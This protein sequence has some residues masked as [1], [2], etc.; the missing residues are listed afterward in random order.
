MQYLDRYS[1]ALGEEFHQRM[2]QG[3]VGG[4]D[5]DL[6]TRGTMVQHESRL[7][8]ERHLENPLSET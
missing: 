1:Q 8:A 3:M 4:T 2:S 6:E 7:C 5:C